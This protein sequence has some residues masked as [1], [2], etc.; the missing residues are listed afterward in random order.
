MASLLRTSLRT[1][2][3]ASS[4]SA[5]PLT[6][7]RG[8]AT[9][10]DLAYDYGA[11][12][13]SVSGK[14]MELHHKNHH[15]TY[16]NSYNTAIEQLQEAQASNDIAAQIALKP[17]INFHGG[18]HINHTLFWEN[19]APKSAGGGE[20]PSGALAKAINES[21]GSLES[22]QGQ[23]N[24]ALAG[25]QGSGWAWLVQD[26]QTG[27]IG[28]K[29]YALTVLKH[30][31]RTLSLVS[32]SPSLVLMPGNTLTKKHGIRAFFSQALRPKKSRQVLRKKS[33]SVSTSDLSTTT[34]LTKGDHDAPP[35][36]P[37]PPLAP[38]QAHNIKYRNV[39]AHQDTQLGESR[40]H[41]AVIHAIGLQ[42]FDTDSDA[43]V[44]KGRDNRPPGEALIA[45][46]P[47]DL[48][49]LITEF[50]SPADA[51]RLAF[52]SRTL[53]SRLGP[54][55][56]RTLN[57]PE[58]TD[59]RADFLVSQDKYYPHHLLCFPC[60][61][62]H[63]RIKEGDE[64]LQPAHVLNPLFDCPNARNNLRPPP[65]HRITHGRT[66]PYTFV[67]LAVRPTRFH[68]PLY[69]LA[70]PSTLSRRWRRNNW[71]HQSRFL[72]HKGHLL[73]RVISSTFAEPGLPPS[74]QRL[75]LYSRDDYWPY[76]SACAHW[77]DG[78]LMSVAKC[79]LTH[80]PHARR[81]EGLQGLEHRAKD[82]IHSRIHNPNAL[83]SLCGHCR[84]MRRC[85][86]CPSEYLV[87]I[88]L[89]E[90][91]EAGAKSRFRHAIVVTRWCDLG[92]GTSPRLSKEWAA[93][94][95][96]LEGYDSFTVLGNR[97]I[98]GTFES[99]FTDDTIPGQRIISMNPSGVRKGEEGNNWY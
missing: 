98:S 79:A 55:P 3:R 80:I 30:R 86:D 94:N 19:L 75:L 88:K 90:E 45:S 37:V 82:L 48:W 29:T 2:L 47:G 34:T 58:H 17:L 14:I 53:Y 11:L 72:V 68:S 74:S 56:W 92:D 76:F 69:G 78:E 27:N 42:N 81:T 63:R 61:R 64:T 66:I 51:A 9:L 24:T 16:V 44:F 20:P 5:A 18:G 40:D 99:A 10:P 36:P 1:G 6:F 62:F 35:V 21:F 65:R 28:I 49:I 22:F 41:T 85:P 8:K 23:M 77:R 15:Q 54:F 83:A 13:P 26:K 52:A 39:H 93:C 25:I 73:M 96:E 71:S 89:T 87:E 50:L 12:E 43:D 60:G 31:T 97:A 84:P 4:S 67:Q 91:R 70:D 32:S 46:L 95:G 33:F 59:D 57:K 7:T 38:L